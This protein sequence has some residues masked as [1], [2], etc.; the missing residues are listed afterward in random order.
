MLENK[1]L[2]ISG[3]LIGS[4]G[5]ILSYIMCKAMNRSFISVIMGG[6][7][8]ES[9][10]TQ[11][12]IE[13]EMVEANSDEVSKSLLSAKSIIIVPGY[14][15]A[16]SRAQNN[17]GALVAAL[18][19]MGKTCRFC[20]HPVAGRLPGHKNVLLAEARVPYDIVMEMDH[21]NK[22]FA[23]TDVVLVIGANDTVNP[24]A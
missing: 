3:A 20:I 15:M 8:I 5:A 12:V 4:S 13:G 2:I 18:R 21:I 14:G 16:V 7:G 24:D 19:K 6:F 1:L 17:V 23:S 22:D 10:T 11:Q 9:S